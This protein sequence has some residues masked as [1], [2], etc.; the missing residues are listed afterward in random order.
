MLNL[1]NKKIPVL[2]TACVKMVALSPSLSEQKQKKE[3]CCCV[4]VYVLNCRNIPNKHYFVYHQ[5]S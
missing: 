3:D 4:T 1:N 5:I 2:S